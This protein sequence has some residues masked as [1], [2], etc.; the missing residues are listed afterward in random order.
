MSKSY[1]NTIGITELPKNI[2]KKIFKMPTDPER[3]KLHHP[4]STKRCPVWSLHKLYFFNKIEEEFIKKSCH[5]ASIGCLDCKKFLINKINI[6]H[7]AIRKNYI[8]LKNNKKYVLR[9]IEK[10]IIN[11]KKVVKKTLFSIKKSIGILI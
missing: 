1:N 2:E 10:G 3:I 4:G 7:Y 8:Y 6:E 9:V 5:T 11:A